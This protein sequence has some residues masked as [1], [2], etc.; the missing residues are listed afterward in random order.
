MSTLPEPIRVA[1]TNIDALRTLDALLTFGVL[2]GKYL[3]RGKGAV[4]RRIGKAVVRSN[5]HF[6]MTRHGARLVISPDSLDV[7]STMRANGNAFDYDDFLVCYQALPD[8]NTFYDIGANVG[9]FSVEMMSL[10][11][12][13]SVVAFE[14]QT[15][16]ARA[17]RRSGD[18]NG[19]DGLKVFDALVGDRTGVAEM[20]VAPA[21]IHSSAVGDS[22]R[23]HHSK[24]RKEMVAIDDLVARGTIAPPDV[25]KVDVEGS[26]HLV[27]RGAAKT[28]RTNRP[29]IFFEYFVHD[30]VGG[31]IRREF[32]ALIADAGCY[33][34][35]ASPTR[36]RRHLYR[37]RLFRFQSDNDWTGIDG[38]FLRN[39]DRQ[40]RDPSFL[41]M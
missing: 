24:L 10:G 20:F 5:K 13:G 22:N 26:E 7:Y 29:H 38:L 39:R 11:E 14:P 4:I 37:S 25:V 23:P 3:P 33:D 28:F 35:Y 15:S 2:C 6:M 9:Y 19:F 34:T 31:R 8:G 30:D 32:D 36:N 17:L 40:V 41:G 21:T 16:L 1:S 18:V 12:P 27:F